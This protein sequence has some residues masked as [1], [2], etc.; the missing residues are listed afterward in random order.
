MKRPEIDQMVSTRGRKRDNRA[1][2]CSPLLWKSIAGLLRGATPNVLKDPLATVAWKGLF[3]SKRTGSSMLDCNRANNV[4][5]SHNEEKRGQARTLLKSVI[6][7]LAAMS[8]DYTIFTAAEKNDVKTLKKVLDAGMDANTR[9][10]DRGATALHLACNKGHVEAIELL[11]DYGADVNAANK[12]GRT[13]IHALIEMRFY[14]IV[15]W[16][17]KYCGGD[18]FKADSRGLTPYDL[19]QAFMQKEID[20]TFYPFPPSCLLSDAFQVCNSAFAENFSRFCNLDLI[21]PL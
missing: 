1:E 15:L 5:F 2:E 12:R 10:Y 18:P 20:G 13:P 14:K 11:I 16:L 19:A 3:S 8:T 4:A 9:D 6:P 21:R 7:C 17:I